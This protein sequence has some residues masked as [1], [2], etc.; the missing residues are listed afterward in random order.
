MEKQRKEIMIKKLNY[1]DCGVLVAIN[2]TKM[3]KK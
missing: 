2:N 3:L 1:G